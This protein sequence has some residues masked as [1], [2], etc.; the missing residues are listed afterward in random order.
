MKWIAPKRFEAPHA[1]IIPCLY[2]GIHWR[3]YVIDLISDKAILVQSKEFSDLSIEQDF[4]VI[5]SKF[6]HIWFLMDY[7]KANKIRK[8]FRNHPKYKR[9][10]F[11]NEAAKR[12]DRYNQLEIAYAPQQSIGQNSGVFACLNM[13]ILTKSGIYT[14]LDYSNKDHDYSKQ[15]HKISNELNANKLDEEVI[16]IK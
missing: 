14:D 1:M 11:W 9:E 10:E 7:L 16:E 15:L 3:F 5:K 2:N 12:V 13:N 8:L 4:Q 6:L